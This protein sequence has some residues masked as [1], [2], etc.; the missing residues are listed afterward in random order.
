MAMKIW[1]QYP[2]PITPFRSVVFQNVISAIDLVR[3]PD[4]EVV[5]N[6]ATKGAPSTRLYAL[7]T[8]K[9]YTAIEMVSRLR[10]AQAEGYDGAVTGQSIDPGL[11]AAKETLDIPVVGLLESASHYAAMWGEAFGLVTIPTPDGY[12]ASKYPSEHQRV[13]HRYGTGS[14]L[15]GVEPMDMNL[16]QMSKDIQGGKHDEIVTKFQDAAR[17]L[18]DRGADVVIAGD[19]IISVVMVAERQ[20]VIPG[21]NQVVVDLITSAIK[22]I[23]GLVDLHRSLGIVRSRAGQ[24]GLPTPDDLEATIRTFGLE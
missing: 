4:T 18:F 1:Y 5:V 17:K 22:Q 19:T 6:P 16:D 2:A 14:K 9:L 11:M 10:H 20:L 8:V 23:E 21:T 12:A 15:I 24:F 13:I 7:E 3:R